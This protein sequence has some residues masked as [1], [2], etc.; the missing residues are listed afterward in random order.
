MYYL[1]F[2]LHELILIYLLAKLERQL[3]TQQPSIRVSSGISAD[4]VV[5]P[6]S[7]DSGIKGNKFMYNSIN[8]FADSFNFVHVP[9]CMACNPNMNFIRLAFKGFS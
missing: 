1:H 8:I 5:N 7:G 4:S 9:A 6:L 2:S 3:P